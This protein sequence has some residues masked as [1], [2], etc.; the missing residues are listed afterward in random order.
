MKAYVRCNGKLVRFVGF[1]MMVIAAVPVLANPTGEKP[2]AELK[3]HATI[4]AAKTINAEAYAS[5]EKLSNDLVKSYEAKDNP[6]RLN[7]KVIGQIHGRAWLLGQQADELA[8]MAETSAKDVESWSSILLSK[9]H[10]LG[11]E[12]SRTPAGARFK[13]QV[14]ARLKK[15]ARARAKFYEQAKVAVAR[16]QGEKVVRTMRPRGEELWQALAFLSPQ[17]RKP[18]E[19]AFGEAYGP[20]VTAMMAKRKPEYAKQAG[21]AIDQ[22]RKDAQQAIASAEAV[23]SQFDGGKFQIGSVQT[24]DPIEAVAAALQTMQQGYASMVNAHTITRLNLSDGSGVGDADLDAYVNSTVEATKPLLDRVCRGVSAD[25]AATHY[26]ELIKAI[27]SAAQHYRDPD[28]FVAACEPGLQ[29]LFAAD[30]ALTGKI[31]AYRRATDPV[32]AFRMAFAKQMTANLASSTYPP[33]ETLLPSRQATPPGLRPKFMKQ[34]PP[35]TVVAPPQIPETVCF[36][37]TEASA[38][39]VG[40]SVSCESM[41]RLSPGSRTGVS[42]YASSHY[43]NAALSIDHQTQ[44]KDL[45]SDL[46]VDDRF[47]PLSPVAAMVLA[48]AEDGDYRSCGGKVARVHCESMATRFATLPSAAASLCPVGGYPETEEQIAPVNQLCWRLDIVPDW[49]AHACFVARAAPRTAAVEPKHFLPNH[50]MHPSPT[51]NLS[52]S[53]ALGVFGGSLPSP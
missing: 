29:S 11:L 32:L 52:A 44:S 34:D 46:L 21:E 30:P 53:L 22:H 27:V 8:A 24:E 17:E 43:T 16:G 49:V 10:Y 20:A 31:A 28:A 48:T 40:S 35:E 47:G 13:Q 36:T 25:Q 42:P 5:I 7:P 4:A 51:R 39:L 38:R 41:Y 23:I 18:Y 50:S 26:A 37:V 1:L 33:T 45:A 14:V 12:S 9:S 6:A 19:Q 15:Q 3:V 2:F